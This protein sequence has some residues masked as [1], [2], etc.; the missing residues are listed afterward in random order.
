MLILEGRYF[1]QDVLVL[2]G[3]FLRQAT[4]NEQEDETPGRLGLMDELLPHF[5]G[6]THYLIHHLPRKQVRDHGALAEVAKR[7]GR[8]NQ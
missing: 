6:R 4:Q 2:C 5:S 3:D 1:L 7:V 8:D